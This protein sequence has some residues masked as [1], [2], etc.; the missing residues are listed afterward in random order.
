MSNSSM[1][2]TKLTVPQLKA[3]CKERRIT[4]YS[5]LGKVALLQKLTDHGGSAI[6]TPSSSK[7]T[8]N[9]VSQDAPRMPVYPGLAIAETLAS[10]AIKKPC[11]PQKPRVVPSSSS[12]MRQSPSI[13]P[14]ISSVRDRHLAFSL[15]NDGTLHAMSP[16][17]LGMSSESS[18]IHPATALSRLKRPADLLNDDAIPDISNKK[19]KRPQNLFAEAN[20]SAAPSNVISVQNQV[21]SSDKRY[22]ISVAPPLV[23]KPAK[24]QIGFASQ[25]PALV[26]PAAISSKQ[27]TTFLPPSIRLRPT[28]H[29]GSPSMLISSNI[30]NT[31]LAPQT[32]E[33]VHKATLPG[34]R[35]KP[36]V[37]KRDFTSP[38]SMP[39]AEHY[40]KAASTSLISDVQAASNSTVPL[41][42]LDF[43]QVPF[44]PLT[45]VSISLPPKLS[46]RKHVH[47]WSVILSGLSDNERRQCVLVSRTFRYSGGSEFLFNVQSATLIHPLL[48]S[49]YQQSTCSRKNSTVAD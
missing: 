15:G 23:P 13:L 7:T 6:G 17:V 27:S 49:I 33:T 2:F 11:A 25:F 19:S 12:S 35:F 26:Q 14:G 32:I 46:K 41:R 48:Q 45:L 1:D 28:L 8:T 47:R 22:S 4:G 37:L 18:H 34:K 38:Q 24:A 20:T 44:S 31:A 36:L 39:S 9:V 40:H 10:V 16:P 42:H 21:P 3:V 43:P 30:V 5:K 29:T